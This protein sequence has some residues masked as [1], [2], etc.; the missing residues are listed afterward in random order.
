MNCDERIMKLLD[1][2]HL[3]YPDPVPRQK[4]EQQAAAYAYYAY[5]R[6]YGE[7]DAEHPIDG[8]KM[9]EAALMYGVHLVNL[10]DKMEWA[11]DNAMIAN[12]QVAAAAKATTGFRKTKQKIKEA[13]SGQS[14]TK[15]VRRTRTERK[16]EPAKELMGIREGEIARA[17]AE[18]AVMRQA[19]LAQ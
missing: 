8:E 1:R 11:L 9:L 3:D 17:R 14:K 5:E 2:A 13:L 15:P 18:G 16:P 10:I 12:E 4:M 7:P 6:M 19:V